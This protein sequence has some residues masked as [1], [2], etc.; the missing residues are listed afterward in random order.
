MVFVLCFAFAG[1][2]NADASLISI[3][4]YDVLNA[5]VSDAMAEMVHEADVGM[6]GNDKR[7]A[8][9]STN[10]LRLW[11]AMMSEAANRAP[12]HKELVGMIQDNEDRT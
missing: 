7:N 11:A 6:G 2:P 3:T 12:T 4:G 10:R 8:L 5:E 9:V 1:A